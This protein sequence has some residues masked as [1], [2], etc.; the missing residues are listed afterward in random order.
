MKNIVTI[1]LQ[2]VKHKLQ[3]IKRNG[4]FFEIFGYD[5]LIDSDFNTLLI[6]ANTNPCLEESSELL[7]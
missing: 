1:S 6:E 2:A 3:P 4:L 5:F 7:S